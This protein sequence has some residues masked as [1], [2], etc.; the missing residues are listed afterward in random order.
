MPDAL[1][2]DVNA[3]TVLQRCEDTELRQQCVDETLTQSSV[4]TKVR[5]AG[6][7]EGTLRRAI[8]MTY[9]SHYKAN[10]RTHEKVEAIPKHRSEAPQRKDAG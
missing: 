10:R 1:T 8:K 2:A 7:T 3:A 4:M 6:S 9:L 5:A